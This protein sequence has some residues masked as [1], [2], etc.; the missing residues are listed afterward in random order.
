MISFKKRCCL[1]EAMDDPSLETEK[2]GAVF[3]DLNRTNLILGGQRITQQA[4]GGLLARFPRDSYS[5]IDMGC[6]D[7]DLLRRLARNC[8]KA[9]IEA[10]FLGIDNSMAALELAAAKSVEFPE[11][12]YRKAS[13]LELDDHKHSCDI[14]L[15]TLTLHHF[16]DQEIGTLLQSFTRMARLGVV[17]NDLQRNR[18]AYYLFHVFSLIFIKT[19]IAKQDGLISIRRGFLRGELH[20]FSS[21]FPD[22]DHRIRWRWV[23]RYLWV[24]QAKAVPLHE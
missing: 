22:F 15:C 2:L 8:R 11:I 18:L 9:Q 3:R 12:Q 16:T 20:C 7:G 13:I 23:F 5:I 19:K 24:M 4:A 14:L 1:E 17:I 10:S 21:A 6:G